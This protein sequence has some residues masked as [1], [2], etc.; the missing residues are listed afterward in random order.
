MQARQGVLER[1]LGWRKVC[2][3]HKLHLEGQELLAIYLDGPGRELHLIRIPNR[4]GMH[5]HASLPWRYLTHAAEG[6]DGLVFEEVSHPFT[7][8]NFT[9]S[10]PPNGFLVKSDPW[11]M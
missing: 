5:H 1:V 9:G 7:T 8:L 10:F 6:A 4:V 3:I 11:N 2:P